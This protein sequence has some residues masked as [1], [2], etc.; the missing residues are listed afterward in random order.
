[1]AG[2][3]SSVQAQETA[4]DTGRRTE[5]SR[6]QQILRSIDD[7]DDHS[8]LIAVHR[9]GYANDRE[10]EAPENSVANVAV[11][12]AKGYEVFETDIQRTADGVFVIVHDATLERETDG[13]GTVEE[14]TLEQL[15]QLHKRYRD[16]TLS[17]HRIATLAELL[18]AGNGKILFKADLK[19]GIIDHFDALARLIAEHP[20]A[21]QV[22]LRTTFRDAKAIKRCFAEGTPKVEIMFKVKKASQVEKVHKRFAPKTIQVDIAKKADSLSETEEEAIRAALALG[23]LVE[24]HAYKSP[25][26]TAALLDAG[27]RMLHTKD[28]DA[29]RKIIEARKPKGQ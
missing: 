18:D 11:A 8:V 24:T 28:P 9:G 5:L 14:K 23:I 25:Q 20:A 1:L 2:A 13:T 29:V 17:D 22:I 3:Y 16:G 10:D 19:P 7:A 6:A 21:E 4:V 15:R 12:V 27:V 26:Q